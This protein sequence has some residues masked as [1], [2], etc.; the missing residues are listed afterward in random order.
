MEGLRLVAD[1]PILRAT[2]AATGIWNLFDGA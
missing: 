2:A 1:S